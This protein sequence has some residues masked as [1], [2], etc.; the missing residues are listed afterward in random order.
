MFKSDKNLCLSMWNSLCSFYFNCGTISRM[1]VTI[2]LYP[3]YE[4]D[5]GSLFA[6]SMR[7]V[8]IVFVSVKT[9]LAT[10]YTGL[11]TITTTIVFI[12]YLIT[13][14]WEAWLNSGIL[15]SNEGV[16]V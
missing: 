15:K 5:S 14:R 7:V 1:W 9:T 6:A 3:A 16:F 8:F 4:H 13:T 2:H 11:I 12:Y 10:L